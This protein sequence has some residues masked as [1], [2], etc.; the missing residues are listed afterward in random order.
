[1][2]ISALSDRAVAMR[3]VEKFEC[4]TADGDTCTLVRSSVKDVDLFLS[5][6]IST[7]DEN[8][9][10]VESYRE[11]SVQLWQTFKVAQRDELPLF[12]NLL[13]WVFINSNFFN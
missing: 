2:I 5:I 6:L 8:F 11:R 7:K 13:I 1:M 12:S 10:I 9:L 3:F 4:S